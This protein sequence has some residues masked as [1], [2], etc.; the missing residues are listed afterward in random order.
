MLVSMRP[1]AAALLSLALAA[2]VTPGHVKAV[3]T[4]DRLEGLGLAVEELRSGITATADTLATLVAKKDQDAAAAFQA[5][6]GAVHALESARRRLEGRVEGVREEAQAYF[7]TWKEQA[8]TIEDEDLKERSEERRAELAAAV[9]RVT[10][11]MD[12]ACKAV[13][14]YLVSLRDTLKYLS[15]DLTPQGIASIDGRAKAASKSSKSVNEELSSLL[16]TVQKAAPLFATARASVPQRVEHD[17][18]TAN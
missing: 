6:E 5:F 2:C 9:E 3:R 13:D 10:K 15:I 16:A 14:A 1:S 17:S 11:G 4:A 8:A 12:P 18:K 7:V